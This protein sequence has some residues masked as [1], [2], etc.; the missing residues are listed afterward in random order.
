MDAD[1]CP[2]WTLH[3]PVS[4]N[5]YQISWPAFE[6]LSRWRLGEV[7]SLLSAIKQETT[8]E[9]TN[10]D[11]ED[12]NAFLIHHH[13]LSSQSP[14]DTER[15]SYYANAMKVSVLMWLLKHYLFFRIPL[16]KPMGLLQKIAPI[17]RYFYTSTFWLATLVVA[18]LSLYFVS[19]EWDTFV[20]TFTAHTT[21]EGLIGIGI[22]LSFAKVTHEFGHAITAHRYGCRVPNMGLAF[23]VMVPMLYTDTNEAWK[24]P[25]KNARVQI[26]AAGMAAEV[27]LAAYATL[28]WSFLPD[29]LLRSGI[30]LLAT[31]TWIITLVIN[32]SPFMRFD[33]YFLLS[34]WLEIPNLHERAFA[35]GKWHLRESLWSFGDPEPSQNSKARKWFLI[36]FAYA[37]WVYRLVLFLGIAFL[38]YHLFFKLLGILLLAVELG[39]FIVFPI[40]RE[41]KIWWLR[42][43]E[44]RLNKALLRTITILLAAFI[45][46]FFP[47]PRKATSPAVLEASQSQWLYAPAPAQ[48][49]ELHAHIRESVKAGQ[50]LVR[51]DSS[52]LRHEIQVAKIKEATALWQVQQQS[53]DSRLLE[54]GATIEHKLATSTAQVSG[55]EA[56]SKKLEL[57]SDFDGTV[58]ALNP[59]LVKEG[60]VGRGEKLIQVASPLGVRI[61]AYVD[62]ETLQNI[63]IGNTARFIADEA[64]IPRISC[65][66]E[67]VDRIPSLELDHASLGS[68]HGGPIPSRNENGKIVP[69]SPRFRVRLNDCQGLSSVIREVNGV[70]AFQYQAGSFAETWMRELI[71]LLQK[72]RGL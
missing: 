13:L 60:W 51:L 52:D 26:S 49:K 20:S 40:W 30:F 16:F 61:E 46:I 14:Q 47:W 22:A 37:T 32:I 18:I 56:L 50:L 17:T 31:S 63:D 29:G 67:S 45:T 42:K 34:D 1:G 70:V 59:A 53:L 35:M 57:R 58:V 21:W 68:V 15:L 44:L 64:N 43:N 36:C 4:N 10:K 33:G 7:S 69:R 38:V 3:D 48:V 72:E 62:E 28:L 24:L 41:L 9:L 12:L 54:Q 11:V 5:F 19:Q 8:L 39:W 55:L 71:S 23:M 2:T 65:V 66:V 6:L 27:A 25:S